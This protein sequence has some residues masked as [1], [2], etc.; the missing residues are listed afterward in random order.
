MSDGSPR[1]TE[2]GNGTS[3]GNPPF[4]GRWQVGLR[5][6]FL[7]MAA[8]AVWLA[9][10]VNRR[11]NAALEAHINAMAPLAHE[12]IV[13]DPKKIA[14]VKLD[15]SWFNENRWDIYLP[16][17]AFRLCM[18][19]HGIDANGLAPVVTSSS[20]ARGTH[21]LVLIE[22]R[23]QDPWRVTVLVDG[24]ELF[25]VAEPKGARSGSGSTSAA[26][27]SQSKQVSPDTPVALIR[28]RLHQADGK[29]G[30]RGIAGAT[31]GVLLWIEPMPGAGTRP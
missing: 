8:I 21:R 7:L 20:M 4:R 2:N 29:G 9:Y 24:L 25:A 28:R 13:G 12:L 31:D 26:D 30:S 22:Q 17:G 19:T 11:H 6:L 14:A 3:A 27:F 16:D 18:A 10:I 15:D 5:T 1:V 23:D